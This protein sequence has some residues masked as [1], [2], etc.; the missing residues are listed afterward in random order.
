MNP[1]YSVL[2]LDDDGPVV[3]SYC[4]SLEAEGCFSVTT[5]TNGFRA[6]E[7]AMRQL[8]DFVVIDAKLNYRG[9]EFGG[10]RLADDLRP[11]FG[12]NSLIVM[13]RYADR[14]SRLL[15]ES[16]PHQFLEKPDG[17]GA[18]VGMLLHEKMKKMK[19][20]QFA[21]VAMPF[22]EHKS[23]IYTELIKPAVEKAGFTSRRTDQISYTSSI[24]DMI[25]SLV[26]DSKFVVFVA[27]GGNPNAYY[28]AGFADALR[29]DVII[30]AEDISSLQFD[31]RHRP[32][33]CYR[34]RHQDCERELINMITQLRHTRPVGR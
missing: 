25:L 6:Y 10:V 15:G 31:I 28:E 17:S 22:A 24:P 27:E 34:D 19:E 32:T 23:Q 8:F 14:V 30:L 1:S 16:D 7:L 18:T 29:K 2:L 3:D 5:E 21:F 33:L 26:R 4:S 9:L 11:R 20:R 12:S 13:S